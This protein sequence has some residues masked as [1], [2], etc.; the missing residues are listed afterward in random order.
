MRV[1]IGEDHPS[2]ALR[3]CSLVLAPYGH[4]DA[5]PGYVGILGPTR[6]NYMRSVAA[7]RFYSSL[8]EELMDTVYGAS[9]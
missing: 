3:D 2:A 9:A 5:A 7:A 8:L 1:L 4:E 6:M